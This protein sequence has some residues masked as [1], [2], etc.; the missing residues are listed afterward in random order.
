MSNSYETISNRNLALDA[1]KV[2]ASVFVIRLHCGIGN[3]LPAY[4]YYLSNCAVPIFFMVNGALILN[5]P[6]IKA[7]YIAKK[8]FNILRLALVWDV[9]YTIAFLLLKK[10]WINPIYHLIQNFHQKGEFSQFWFLGTLV[11]VYILLPFIYPLLN[12]NKKALAFFTLS[13]GIF[14]ILI[15]TL[16]AYGFAPGI[17]NIPKFLKIWIWLFYFCLGG[18]IFKH[19]S[20]LKLHTTPTQRLTLVVILCLL[21]GP[22]QYALAIT[23]DLSNSAI[24]VLNDII[25]IVWNISIV[26]YF[27]CSNH[28][29]RIIQK[30]A[31]LAP[32]T[33]GIYIVHVP[34]IQLFIR[35]DIWDYS[36]WLCNVVIITILAYLVT[37]TGLKIPFTNFL[38]KL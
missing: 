20:L 22:L 2:M 38:F 7:H 10:E 15:D 32:F 11:L 23:P 30:I 37:Y 17:V 13:L 26:I 24:Y 9:L 1:L 19:L 27:T 34:L 25:Y 28:N 29:K 8:V 5:K 35:L 36:M 16:Y 21:T 31:S 3:F 33:I 4:T 6:A 18:T 14:C 12:A